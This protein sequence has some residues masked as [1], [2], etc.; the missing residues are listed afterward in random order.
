[1]YMGPTLQ[2]LATDNYMDDAIELR[3]PFVPHALKNSQRIL[4][5]RRTGRKFVDK[6]KAAV[7]DLAA[8]RRIVMEAWPRL[9]TPKWPT[10]S[11]SLQ[12]VYNVDT[13]ECVVT[14][15]RLCERRKK[16]KTGRARD[17]HN[18]VDAIAD[19]LQVRGKSG[20]VGIVSDDNQFSRID[21]IRVDAD[22]NVV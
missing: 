6:S 11:V 19:A 22:G 13:D 1:M 2:I 4:R 10:E 16:G 17:L 7:G 5:N 14:I 18:I 9:N 20:G 3:I 15:R 12:V 8:L 21:L